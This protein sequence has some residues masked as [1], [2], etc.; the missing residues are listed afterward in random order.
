MRR[1]GATLLRV[2]PV[3]ER[4]DVD[5]FLAGFFDVTAKL[6]EI[7]V[8]VR[9]IRYLLEEDDDGEEEEDDPAA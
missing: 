8:D 9:A 5:A 6:E 1:Q 3:V 2:E 4:A 7:I